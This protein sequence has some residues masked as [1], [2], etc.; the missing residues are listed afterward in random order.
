MR[1]F[2]EVAPLAQY[3]N[4][5]TINDHLQLHGNSKISKI[6][7]RKIPLLEIQ[8]RGNKRM[9]WSG[10]EAE[11][12]RLRYLLAAKTI[13]NEQLRSALR[14]ESSALKPLSTNTLQSTTF[15]VYVVNTYF[16]PISVS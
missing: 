9:K 6:T 5:L 11:V 1:R 16:S 2:A 7:L 12:I 4:P 10:L 13:E 15:A 14:E 3:E 8:A